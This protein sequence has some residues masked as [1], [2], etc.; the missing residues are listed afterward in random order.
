[1]T[2][3][4]LFRQKYRSPADWFGR[5]DMPWARVRERKDEVNFKTGYGYYSGRTV[6]PPVRSM[7]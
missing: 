2:G 7:P 4:Y 6:K 1:M 5:I 3:N